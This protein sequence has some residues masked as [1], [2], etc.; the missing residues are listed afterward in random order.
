[1]SWR[2]RAQCIQVVIQVYKGSFYSRDICRYIAPTSSQATSEFRLEHL[3][4]FNFDVIDVIVVPLNCSPII[5]DGHVETLQVIQHITKALGS[6][7][8]T[9]ILSAVSPPLISAGSDVRLSICDLLITHSQNDPSLLP[10][11]RPAFQYFFLI[12][13]QEL[14]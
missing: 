9:K 2:K 3:I 1:M 12:V 5:A 7:A 11:V 14:L 10:V 4:I 8:T 6:E 13:L